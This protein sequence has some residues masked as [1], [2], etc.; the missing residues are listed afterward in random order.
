M[1]DRGRDREK[2]TDR[3]GEEKGGGGREIG[4]IQVS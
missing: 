1:S 4:T 3:E 2:E